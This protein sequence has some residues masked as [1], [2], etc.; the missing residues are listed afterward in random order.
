MLHLL[1]VVAQTAEHDL[2]IQLLDKGTAPSV[3]IAG[4]ILL[5]NLLIRWDKER[6][7]ADEEKRDA[8]NAMITLVTSQALRASE[9]SSSAAIASRDASYAIQAT[10]RALD[11]LTSEVKEALN[12]RNTA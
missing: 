11:A 1:P 5:T 2:L 7:T 6:R 12:E 8:Q 10:S 4:L 9:A 3:F